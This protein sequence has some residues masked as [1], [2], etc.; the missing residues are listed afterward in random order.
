MSK[1]PLIDEANTLNRSCHFDLK[2]GPFDGPPFNQKE[3]CLHPT[4]SQRTARDGRKLTRACGK[5]HAQSVLA[6]KSQ[7]GS[8]LQ[9]TTA[10]LLRCRNCFASTPRVTTAAAACGHGV[11][12]ATSQRG[13]SQ[14]KNRQTAR[15]HAAPS[16]KRSDD[17]SAR[18]CPPHRK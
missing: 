15:T 4:H 17:P 1:C 9:D 13:C 14:A 5:S 6:S 11:T 12:S 18:R 10:A 7:Q 16:H 3:S 2:G 8:P